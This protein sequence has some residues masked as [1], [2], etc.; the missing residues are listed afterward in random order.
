[1]TSGIKTS[2]SPPKTKI[3]KE[4]GKEKLKARLSS[5]RGSPGS[6]FKAV[7]GILLEIVTVFCGGAL[8]ELDFW[9]TYSLEIGT[10]PHTERITIALL[11]NVTL[12]QLMVEKAE[13][14]LLQGIECLGEAA[15]EVWGES[16]RSGSQPFFRIL[17]LM[18][19]MC[20]LLSLRVDWNGG[21][22]SRQIAARL[23]RCFSCAWAHAISRKGAVSGAEFARDLADLIGAQLKGTYST[24]G[25]SGDGAQA[26][27]EQAIYALRNGSVWYIGRTQLKHK[28][29]VAMGGLAI[30]GNQHF[31]QLIYHFSGKDKNFRNRYRHL[32]AGGRGLFAKICVLQYAAGEEAQKFETWAMIQSEPAANNLLATPGI[33]IPSVGKTKK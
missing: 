16:H 30:R 8:M 26:N 14:E 6:F 12:W 25:A 27:G 7:S 32:L 31:K 24:S 33:K 20:F 9:Q 29:K 15:M 11:V 1:M 5:S 18:S 23:T 22:K 2:S 28:A 17:T 21:F 19:S 3:K 4:W 10:L 13:P